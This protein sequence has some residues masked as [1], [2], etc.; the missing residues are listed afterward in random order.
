[1]SPSTVPLLCDFCKSIADIATSLEGIKDIPYHKSLEGIKTASLNGCKL[2]AWVLENFPK[3]AI[4]KIKN[5]EY[6][7][8]AGV[9]YFALMFLIEKAEALKIEKQG[10]PLGNLD[11]LGMFFQ[12]FYNEGKLSYHSFDYD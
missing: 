3:F 1:M 10:V 5:L 4:S 9:Q 11:N 6:I 7:V 12:A 2:C 8:Q